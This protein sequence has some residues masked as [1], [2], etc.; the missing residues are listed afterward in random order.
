M[1]TGV[2]YD[3]ARV[4]VES[5]NA[6]EGNT[7]DVDQLIDAVAGVEFPS[8]RGTFKFDAETHNV[9]NPV[10]IREVQDVGGTLHNVVI[11][12]LGEFPDPG[13]DSKG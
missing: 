5:L 9:I 10:Y 7:S 6:V 11:D 8:P 13:D 1:A 2:G 12:D 4:I 3:T